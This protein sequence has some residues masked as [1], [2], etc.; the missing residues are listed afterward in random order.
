MKTIE[1]CNCG[2]GLSRRKVLKAGITAAAAVAMGQSAESFAGSQAQRKAQSKQA[3]RAA[4]ARAIDIH[5]HYYPQAYLDTIAEDGKRFNA[6]AHTT[7]HGFYTTTPAGVQGPLPIKMVELKQRIAEMDETGVTMQ[8]L[9]LTMPMNY[10]GDA[11]I[12]LKLARAWNDGASAAHAP[13]VP[14]RNS[15]QRLRRHARKSCSLRCD[16]FRGNRR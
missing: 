8:A 10:W 2:E 3:L 12:S 15:T 1:G 9:S 16:G 6:E 14:L 7:S 13:C 5:A 11:D 4:G